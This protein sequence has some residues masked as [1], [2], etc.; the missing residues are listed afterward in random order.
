MLSSTGGPGSVVLSQCQELSCC[1]YYELEFWY[2]SD[3]EKRDQLRNPMLETIKGLNH[4]TKK[5]AGCN[6]ERKDCK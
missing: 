3:H 4:A 5:S 2:Q 1:H 6:Y